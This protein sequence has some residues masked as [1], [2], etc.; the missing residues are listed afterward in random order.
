MADLEA[1]TR[2]FARVM[3]ESTL[4]AAVKDGAVSNLTTLTS[5]TSFR[6]GDGS[7]H[8]W[9]GCGNNAGQGFGS[10][11]HV[12]HYEVSTDFVFPSLARSMRETYFDYATD[13]DGKMDFRH[14]LPLGPT[15]KDEPHFTL[16]EGNHQAA[17]DGQMGEIIHLYLDWRICGDTKWMLGRWPKAKRALEFAWIKG[18]WDANK[19]GVMEGA[20]HNT[21]DLEFV[22]PTGMIQSYYLAGLK[23][24]AAMARA[25][26]DD[27]F[28]AECDRIFKAGSEWTDAHLF[29]GEFY[30]QQINN[31]P[32]TEFDPRTMAANL[33]AE[34]SIFQLGQACHIDQVI[35][36]Y[37]ASLA[38]LGDLLAP[39]NR[40]KALRS[41]IHWNNRLRPGT[42]ENTQRLY[43]INDEPAVNICAYKTDPDLPIEEMY[44]AW[45]NW[46]GLENAFAA[47]LV[48][49][50]LVAEGVKVIEDL[51]GRNDG[52]RR[53]PF[54]EIEW[55]HHYARSMS[56]WAMIPALTGFRHDAV[57]G[58]LF[59]L[60][61]MP[62]MKAIWIA[63]TGWGEMSVA[64]GKLTLKALAGTLTF[65]SLTT[66]AGKK[67][68]AAPVVVTVE[69]PFTGA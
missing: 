25:A 14:K 53:N 19:D 47:N 33:W 32:A 61:K 68:F 29:N 26:G 3:A 9:E 48:Q 18:G 67:S 16:K 63:N 57:T 17:A 69:K 31:A 43:S 42:F 35:G 49:H 60:P 4:P 27:A 66:A 55:G 45:E 46:N 20:Q 39:A 7:F 58:E 36:Q 10:C 22:G 52:E 5:N 15:P 11:S 38:G 30:V 23:A 50:G 54:D 65:S 62:N 41:T 34:G 24:A 59:V 56:S 13:K 44:Y 12:W 64:G 51:R 37:L 28:A 1:K 2:A 21:Y 40:M 8:G 6:I